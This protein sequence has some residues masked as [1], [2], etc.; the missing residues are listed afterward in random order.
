MALQGT[1][2]ELPLLDLLEIFSRYY[3]SGWLSVESTKGRTEIY[4][5]AGRIIYAES[6]ADREPLGKMLL[7][8]GF[9]TQ[10]R[11]DEALHSQKRSEASNVPAKSQGG[12]RRMLGELLLELGIVTQAD[13][14]EALADQLAETVYRT[15]LESDGTFVYKVAGYEPP[16][17]KVVVKLRIDEVVLRGMAR[18]EDMSHLGIGLFSFRQVPLLADGVVN[19]KELDLPPE[20]WKVLSL[21]DGRRNLDEI[22]MA[23]NLTRFSTARALFNLLGKRLV[24]IGIGASP[25]PVQRTA[26]IQAA[27]PDTETL[28]NLKRTLEGEENAG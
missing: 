6:V 15:S 11:L 7:G 21:I 2:A 19:L 24:E 13:I 4:I 5:D 23:G 1:L 3:R 17:S 12:G 14:E 10:E 22:T 18:V 20:E 27:S 8:R 28:E 9:L 16:G 26:A 25:P